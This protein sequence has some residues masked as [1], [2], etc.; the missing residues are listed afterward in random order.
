MKR[1]SRI[2]ST[3]EKNQEKRDLHTVAL[4]QNKYMKS[5]AQIHYDILAELQSNPDVDAAAV[6]IAVK[7][8]VVTLAGMVYSF[9]GKV[10]LE[11]TVKRVSGVRAVADEL[12]IGPSV[13]SHLEDCEVAQEIVAA[14]ASSPRVDS[15]G[16]K[17]VVDRGVVTLEG[18]VE[19][20]LQR[21]A[22]MAIVRALTGVQWINN[23]LS[24]KA[25]IGS[26]QDYSIY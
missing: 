20:E 14:L 7:N 13:G 22:V 3:S 5:D 26:L 25:Q 4:L 16:I 15:S 2:S 17:V 23:R 12:V 1:M 18:A 21:N 10:V 6:G 9:E 8:G 24:L 11:K 19:S